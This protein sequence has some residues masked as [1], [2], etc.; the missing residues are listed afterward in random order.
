MYDHRSYDW[1]QCLD[2]GVILRRRKP[3]KRLGQ[4]A[5]LVAHPVAH[6]RCMATMAK[7]KL[8]S[9]ALDSFKYLGDH[10]ALSL[11][12]SQR[13]EA[14]E[15]HHS[16]IVEAL[17]NGAA[18]SIREGVVIWKRD[19]PGKPPLSLVLGPSKLAPMEGELQLTFSFRSDLHVLTFLFAPGHVFNSQSAK[20]LFIGGLQGRFGARQEVR[21]AS[22][23]NHEIAPATM[24]ILAV[25]AIARA[26]GANQ[27]LAVAETEQISMSYS[28]QAVRFDYQSFWEE[29]GGTRQGSYY[30]IPIEAPHKSLSAVPLTHRS[31]AK[32][33]R[34][35]KARIRDSIE[36]SIRDLL[37]KRVW[38]L[39]QLS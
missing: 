29:L 18:N 23:L 5:Y 20:V 28:P 1:G 15:Q 17:S 27:I 2:L 4:L 25:R 16:I 32:R 7:S 14:L 3:L 11:R 22:K 39:A 33:K 10:L 21:E 37:G 13:R 6:R 9:S 31:R 12:T 30:S 19:L 24:L 8:T 36:A 26:I 34:E 35:E 38:R